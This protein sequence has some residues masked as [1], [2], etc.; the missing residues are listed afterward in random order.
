MQLL[1][2]T[3]TCGL[4][5]PLDASAPVFKYSDIHLA[6]TPVIRAGRYSR[7]VYIEGAGACRRCMVHCV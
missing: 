1:S 4:Q 6:S 2:L 3:C 7:P 5:L